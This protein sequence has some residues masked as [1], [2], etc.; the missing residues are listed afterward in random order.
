MDP[1]KQARL[2]AAGFHVTNDPRDLLD[3]LEVINELRARVAELERD[4]TDLIDDRERM[5]TGLNLIANL[6]DSEE[7]RI[8]RIHLT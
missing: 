7:S 5:R 6:R 4:I 3:P 8:A 1:E 2:E